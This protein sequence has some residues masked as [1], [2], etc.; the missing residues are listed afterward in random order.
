MSHKRKE[1][2]MQKVWNTLGVI[3]IRLAMFAA[4]CAI[5]A[6]IVFIFFRWFW[7]TSVDK[8]EFAFS[9]N[10]FTGGIETC[11]NSGWYV[12]TPIKYSVYTI[13][14]RPVQITISA[15]QRVLN[16]KLVRFNPEGIETFIKW[17]G[18]SAASGMNSGALPEILKCY[19][20][21]SVGGKDCPFLEV[22]QDIA[23]NQGILNEKELK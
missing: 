21:D 6:L 15:N 9:F 13:D 1:K 4:G 3:G 16:A 10:R 8:H 22:I 14:C 12:R 19:A 2:K 18:M 17:H 20:F 7:V 11:T 5:G 23:P